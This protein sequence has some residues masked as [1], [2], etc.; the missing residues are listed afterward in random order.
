[1]REEEG[2]EAD[3]ERESSERLV[4]SLV[5]YREVGH[6]AEPDLEATED[7]GHEDVPHGAVE[8]LR[9]LDHRV[10][11]G[12]LE[13]VLDGRIRL[14]EFAPAFLAHGARPS[15]VAPLPEESPAR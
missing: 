1:M 12:L 5:E 10:V 15:F 14:T 9:A 8:T 13:F 11:E 7:P 6:D 4:A 3:T 2:H